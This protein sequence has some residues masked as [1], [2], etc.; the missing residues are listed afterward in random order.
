MAAGA[1]SIANMDISAETSVKFLES[2]I[3]ICQEGEITDQI[4]H[5]ERH[6]VQTR[7]DKVHQYLNV[8]EP[9]LGEQENG[10]VRGS[11]ELV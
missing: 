8:D 1:H 11:L 5:R 6:R 4:I 7:L 3:L 9:N 10:P 2:G